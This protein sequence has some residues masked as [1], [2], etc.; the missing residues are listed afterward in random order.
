M[1]KVIVMVLCIF[2]V[3]GI[4]MGTI[5]S[6]RAGQIDLHRVYLRSKIFAQR[7]FNKDLYRHACAYWVY[8]GLV[9][10]FLLL[11]ISQIA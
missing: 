4:V 6:I 7:I 2:V 9:G 8:Y 11:I 10:L 3:P 5:S 1:I